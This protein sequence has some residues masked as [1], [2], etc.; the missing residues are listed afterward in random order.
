MIKRMN[1]Q[2]IAEAY[3]CKEFAFSADCFREYF[4]CPMGI[5]VVLC[6]SSR[7]PRDD[8]YYI[9]NRGVLYIWQLQNEGYTLDLDLSPHP[10]QLDYFL[11]DH[12]DEKVYVWCEYYEE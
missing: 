2:L 5:D 7:K 9:L 10:I 11:C 3:S 12:F 6:V 8:E 1:L 4:D